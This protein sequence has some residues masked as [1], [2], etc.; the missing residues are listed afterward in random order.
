[1]KDLKLFEHNFYSQNGEDGV[2][3][4]ILQRLTKGV[5]LTH[6][7]VEFG[8]WDG[9]YLSNTC[10]L[11]RES[12]YQAVLIEGDPKRVKQLYKNFPQKNVVKVCRFVG[13]EGENTIDKILSETPISIDFDFLSID[14]DG[15]DYYILESIK[16]YTPKVICIEFNPS[17]PNAVDFVQVKNF[18]IKQGSSAQ[19]L[20]RL[21]KVKGYKLVHSTLC[22][23]IFVRSDLIDLV[24]TEEK[25]I[26]DLN[27]GG[28]DP[29]FLFVGYDGTLLS[30]KSNVSLLW[31]KLIVPIEW[32]QPL[33]KFLRIFGGN[34]GI[35]RRLFFSLWISFKN[36]LWLF[37]KIK[38]KLIK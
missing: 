14:I 13:F 20:I 4:E 11:I 3:A 5:T 26:E 31:H 21:A 1:M 27:L 30:N 16:N 32:L 19:A 36:P 10:R 28:N 25:T 23:L 9:V 12:N 8:A 17:I 38:E 29:T 34:Y 35:F 2:I 15:A 18:N 37:G 24:I 6:W 22:N 7:C 33:P